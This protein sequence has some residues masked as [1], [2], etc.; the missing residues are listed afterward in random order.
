MGLA[1]QSVTPGRT[2]LLEA[3]NVLLA[4]IGEAPVATLEDEQNAEAGVA[5]RTILELHKEGQTRGWTWNREEAVRFMRDMST[6]EVV[7]PANV[8][9]FSVDRF[10]WAHRFQLR[11]QR[12]YDKENRTFELSD[13][14]Y[15]EADVVLLLSWDDCP[16]AY[17]RWVV[18]RA[19]RVFAERVLASD[20]VSQSTAE[21][22]QRAWA[23]LLRVEND[24]QQPNVL[25]A[26]PGL[27]PFPTFTP[28]HGVT[29]ARRTSIFRG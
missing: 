7:V 14:A 15:I 17:N 27:R 12:V 2:T 18:A 28:G 20:V 5:E 23:E 11:G 21:Q 6:D 8:V 16:E 9:A 4:N 1:N 19:S 29:V 3:V 13:F 10:Q 26:G 24:Q 22:E 25:T